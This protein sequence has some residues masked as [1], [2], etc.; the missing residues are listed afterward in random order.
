M[1]FDIN[2]CFQFIKQTLSNSE[3]QGL[4]P[5]GHEPCSELAE[6]GGV[7]ARVGQLQAQQI[8]PVDPASDGFG[9][10]PV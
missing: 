4:S 3:Q 10:P 8:L 9:R 5:T 6:H 1:G 2:A 7:E